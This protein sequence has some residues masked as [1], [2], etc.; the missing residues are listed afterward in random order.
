MANT[1]GFPLCCSARV[2]NDF[3]GGHVGQA[4]GWTKA[5][6]IKWLRSR[7]NACKPYYATVVAIVTTTQ[8]NA[9]AA[10]EEVGFYGHPDGISGGGYRPPAKNHKMCVMFMPLNEWDEKKFLD[11]YNPKKDKYKDGP[12]RG[13]V[14]DNSQASVW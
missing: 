2:F 9:F 11:E 13:Y 1:T 7:L 10:L 8:P 14:F 12:N 3:G 5:E 6:L 4:E